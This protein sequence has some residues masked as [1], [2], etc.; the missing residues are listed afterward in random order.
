MVKARVRT[1]PRR[2]NGP[3]TVSDGIPANDY[4]LIG[5]ICTAVRIVRSGA[6]GSSCSDGCRPN[7]LRTSACGLT[8]NSARETIFP[9]RWT[10][11]Y[12]HTQQKL[13][14]PVPAMW[15]ATFTLVGRGVREPRHPRFRVT[16]TL[17]KG[18]SK[19]CAR[20]AFGLDVFHL[21]NRVNYGGFRRHDRLAALFSPA[22]ECR[23]RRGSCNS[24]FGSK[25]LM[26]RPLEQ[27]GRAP[28]RV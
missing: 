11:I 13:A 2:Q 7:P 8:M 27:L 17:A 19:S 20:L 12:K 25:Q 15:A 23:G 9:V 28:E 16:V 4:D 14:A 22:G 24:R 3:P 1:E 26:P 5:L 21:S 18:R 10:A 6:F